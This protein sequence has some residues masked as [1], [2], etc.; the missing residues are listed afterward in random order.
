MNKREFIEA[1][2]LAVIAT[3]RNFDI[4]EQVAQLSVAYDA[5]P[6]EPKIDLDADGWRE[7]NGQKPYPY[8]D[9]EWE[10]RGGSTGVNNSDE[11][12]WEWDDGD[13]WEIV[14]YRPVIRW[15]AQ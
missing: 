10:T 3:G 15:M 11:L 8:G 14:R 6:G 7:W 4:E 12:T 13:E 1:G 5:I 2:L 9:V